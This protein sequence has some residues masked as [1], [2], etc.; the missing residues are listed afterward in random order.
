MEG[1]REVRG[2]GSREREMGGGECETYV[3]QIDL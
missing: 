2:R 1:E 3:M